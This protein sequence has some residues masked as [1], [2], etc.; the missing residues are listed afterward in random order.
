MFDD[1]VQSITRSR[2]LRT[3]AARCRD[4]GGLFGILRETDVYRTRCVLHR[5]RLAGACVPPLV[6]LVILLVIARRGLPRRPTRRGE[7]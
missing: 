4:K 3:L 6:V 1:D 5:H 2:Y 7:D